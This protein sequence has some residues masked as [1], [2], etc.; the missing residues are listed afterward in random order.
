MKNINKSYIRQ[1]LWIT[2][3]CLIYLTSLPGLAAAQSIRASSAIV[4]NWDTV[5]VLYEQNADKA[6]APAS[7]TKLMTMYLTFDAIKAGEISL[8]DKVTVSSRA[9]GQGGSC[10][11]LRTGDQVTVRQLL[12]GMAVASGNDASYAM[13]EFLAGSESAFI[14]RMNEKA[15]RLGM[16]N[17]SF[18]SCHG[19][20]R[21]GQITTARDM[22]HLCR[23]YLAI[24][25]QALTYH[26]A[27]E[28]TYRGKTYTNS[29]P[30]LDSYPGADGL[31]TGYTN[32]SAYNL[33]VTARQGGTR[34]IAIILGAN[35]I[36]IRNQEIKRLLDASFAAAKGNASSV[37]SALG[38]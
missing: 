1:L 18:G 29:N 26:S 22:L 7:L 10:M 9:A 4:L 8:S 11:G 19:L 32:A 23:N 20:P 24:H 13:A 35:T 25:P 21:D 16:T 34:L 12:Y 17:T 14:R 2:C 28:F 5:K 36:P 38:G 6:W 3:L 37:A 15:R 30:M 33:I 31:K 27:T